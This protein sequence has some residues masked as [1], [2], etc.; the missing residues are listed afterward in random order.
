MTVREIENDIIDY[1][2]KREFHRIEFIK[3]RDRIKE[4]NIELSE[5]KEEMLNISIGV[6]INV[7]STHICGIYY[8][9]KG[10]NIKITNIT[11]KFISGIIMNGKFLGKNSGIFIATQVLDKKFRVNKTNFF[12]FISE[13]TDMGVIIN[14]DIIIDDILS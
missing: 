3:Y 13:H 5:K 10:S 12:K 9:T 8:F 1:N 2:V 4:L 11:N 14:R 7:T 6:E